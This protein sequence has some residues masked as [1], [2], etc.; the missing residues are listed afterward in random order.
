MGKWLARVRKHASCVESGRFETVRDS[1]RYR[2]TSAPGIGGPRGIRTP[3]S[4]LRGPEHLFRIRLFHHTDGYA[5]G[6]FHLNRR[7]Q[8][9]PAPCTLNGQ[10]RYVRPSCC[11][12]PLPFP[13]SSS[14]SFCAGPRFRLPCVGPTAYRIP[15]VPGL[16]KA[17]PGVVDRVVLGLGERQP[18]RDHSRLHGRAAP[19]AV[20]NVW[21][22]RRKNE[23]RAAQPEPGP[24]ALDDRSPVLFLQLYAG[25]GIC[26]KSPTRWI[27]GILL[28]VTIGAAPG[29]AALGSLQNFVRAPKF[30]EA[31]GRRAEIRLVGPSLNA[32]V[33]GAA[34]R[35]WVR[36][37]N[38]NA[39]AFTLSTLRGTL[40]LQEARAA[41][42]GFA[43]GPAARSASRDR[44]PHRSAD[45]FC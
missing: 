6:S 4:A 19:R 9:R 25:G 10:S 23:H 8:Q 7:R 32:P 40:F 12:R 43:A 24:P 3:V 16:S 45:Q 2:P 17:H 39:F 31:P 35:L 20:T 37:S 1:L 44:I 14:I 36:V 30:D 42:I 38:P 33:G 11:V 18:R 21:K 5:D 15:S 29:C 13:P 28:I 22:S 27:A 41:T 34:V 26:M